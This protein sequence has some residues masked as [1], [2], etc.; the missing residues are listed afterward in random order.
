MG[1]GDAHRTAPDIPVIDHETGEKIVVLAGR[2][3]VIQTHADHLVGGARAPVPGAVLRGENIAAILGGERG[4]AGFG[5]GIKR[6]LQRGRVS[7][8]QHVGN[9]HLAGEVG[10]LAGMAGVLVIAQIKPGPAVEGTLFHACDVVRH[11]VIAQA[12]T[13]VGRG[14][15]I[16]RI[17]MNGDAH[18]IANAVRE[19]AERQLAFGICDQDC[20]AIGLGVPARTQA[21]LR[22][23]GRG[24]AAV[25][26]AHAFGDVRSRTDRDEEPLAVEGKSNVARAVAAVALGQLRY[27]RFGRTARLQVAALIRDAHHRIIVPH[28][29]PLGMISRRIKSDPERPVET[30]CKNLILRGAFRPVGGAQHA[31][32]VGAGLHDE[33]IAVR[34]HAYQARIRQPRGE[35]LDGESRRDRQ[36]GAVRLF[37]DMG[38]IAGRTGR[39]GRRQVGDGDVVLHAGRGVLPIAGIGGGRSSRG[40]RDGRSGV[41]GLERS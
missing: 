22:V 13:L 14:P 39:V 10:P 34:R 3:P 30:L 28:V 17:G 11:E 15:Q 24:L 12:V 26:F 20:G 8:Q 25:L 7:L 33:N 9:R 35:K 27:D 1:D 19:G 32:A 6:H 16:A 36:R 40:G 23:P 5:R 4:A 18:A 29:N 21:V 2:N 31:N 37:H 38:A 41:G